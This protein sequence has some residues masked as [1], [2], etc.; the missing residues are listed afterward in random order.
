[1]ML[2]DFLDISRRRSL[3]RLPLFKLQMYM[4]QGLVIAERAI[5]HYRQ[6]LNELSCRDLTDEE[7]ISADESEDDADLEDTKETKV[8]PSDSD[9]VRLLKRELYF[10]KMEVRA[11]RD[12]ADGIA[13]RLFDYDR[14]VLHE[15]S[16][17][18]TGKHINLAG[19]EA[20][21]QALASYF[22]QQDGVAVLNDLTNFLKF[23]DITVRRESGEFEIVEVKSGSSGGGRVTRQRQGLTELVTVL[24]MDQGREI[25]GRAVK[26]SSVDVQPDMFVGNLRT[27]LRRA[28]TEGAAVEI[29]GSHLLIECFDKLAIIER[30]K[31]REQVFAILDRA[32]P[33]LDKWKGDFV[34]RLDAQQR[35]AHAQN[36][37]PLS[38]FPLEPLTCV[39]LISGAV[40]L[41]AYLNV[42]AVLRDLEGRGWEVV[43]SP[44]QL[45]KSEEALTGEVPMAVLRK[46]DFTTHV[47][48]TLFGRLGM[49]FLKPRSLALLFD[50]TAEQRDGGGYQLVNF[51][52]ESKMWR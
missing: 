33:A 49:E 7:G 3:T 42:S 12:I 19:L 51:V 31:Q 14:A 40:D 18:P 17:R 47:P 50:A 29:V 27:L 45:A 35:Y 2:E 11:L 43:K 16:R 48:A 36:Y 32:K 38:I 41:D 28:E 52:G 22:N 37:V 26:I 6:V 20:E 4:L 25:G 1:M 15:L 30:K 39:R 21:L 34:I 5:A 44:L 46:R 13:W 8:A 9:E 23:G 24:S 10:N